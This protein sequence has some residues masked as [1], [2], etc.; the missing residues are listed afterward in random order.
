MNSKT[1]LTYCFT[2]KREFVFDNTKR[3]GNIDK[4]G[5]KCKVSIVEREPNARFQCLK[6]TV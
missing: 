2:D 4:S 3:V 5:P 1:K 6:L